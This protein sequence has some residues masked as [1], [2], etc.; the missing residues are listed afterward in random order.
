MRTLAAGMG[1]CPSVW[2][3]AQ[4]KQSQWAAV[5]M[6]NMT[7]ATAI[8]DSNHTG[9]SLH[10]EG[11]LNIITRRARNVR[12]VDDSIAVPQCLCVLCSC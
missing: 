2:L 8:F 6:L 9:S 12:Y 5:T 11:H 1:K 7:L 4:R 3:S 10:P